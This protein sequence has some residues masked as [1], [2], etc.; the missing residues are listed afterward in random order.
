[1][2]KIL[3]ICS[4]NIKKGKELNYETSQ[5]YKEAKKVYNDVIIFNPL[6]ISIDLKNNQR[7]PNVYFKNTNLNK[8]D[9]LIVRRL[10]DCEESTA[11]LVHSLKE[12][13]CYITDSLNRFQGQYPSKTLTTLK[14]YKANVGI[15]TYFTFKKEIA[16]NLIN[17]LN[18]NSEFPLLLKPISGKGGKGIE[19]LENLEQATKILEDLFESNDSDKLTIMFQKYVEFCSEYRVMLFNDYCLGIAEKK[20]S[21]EIIP[22]NAQQGGKYVAVDSPEVIDFAIQNK[23]QQGILGI[24]VARDKENNLYILEENYAPKWET[25]D[26]ALESNIAKQIINYLTKFI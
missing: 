20:Q 14:R 19:Y 9:T 16:I 18:N 26:Q 1:M 3:G 24:D 25:L 6:D 7:Q 12:C 13:G 8:I 5:V 11:I 15:N 2:M 4:S 22:A 23:T 17:K 10:G 21:K